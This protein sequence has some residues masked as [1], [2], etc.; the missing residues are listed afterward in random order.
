MN[1]EMLHLLQEYP[2]GLT[3]I[4]SAHNSAMSIE[5]LATPAEPATLFYCCCSCADLVL[6]GRYMVPAGERLSESF[7]AVIKK[8]YAELVDAGQL[9]KDTHVPNFSLIQ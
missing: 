6:R 3:P 7:A 5:L 9:Q 4:A 8:A 1:P 2:A